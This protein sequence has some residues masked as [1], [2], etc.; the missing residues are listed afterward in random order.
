MCADLEV[1]FFDTPI[2]QPE[3][4]KLLLS[5]QSGDLFH[6]V[7]HRP[8]YLF[9]YSAKGDKGIWAVKGAYDWYS[10]PPRRGRSIARPGV[11]VLLK[12]VNEP[13]GEIVTAEH[14]RQALHALPLGAI[15]KRDDEFLRVLKR[16]ITLNNADSAELE[17]TVENT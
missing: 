5:C 13:I 17:V 14:M 10:Q 1:F 3:V 15:F 16:T 8:P 4:K 2:I 9:E 11:R 7:Q 6:G 12:H